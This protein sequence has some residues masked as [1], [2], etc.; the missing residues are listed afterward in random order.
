MVMGMASDTTKTKEFS[1]LNVYGQD[2]E[3]METGNDAFYQDLNLL[4]VIDK[5]TALW[6]KSVRKLFFFLPKSAPETSYRRDVYAD[7]KNEKVYRALLALTEKLAHVREM[8]NEKERTSHRLQR[9][10]WKLREA[11][12]YC[13]AYEELAGALSEAQLSSDGMREF[14]AHLTEILTDGGFL[15]MRRETQRLLSEIQG[16]RFI[17]TYERDRISV[18]PVEGGAPQGASAAAGQRYEEWLARFDGGEGAGMPNPFVTEPTLSE[19]EKACL[20]ML[21]S[22]KPEFFTALETA[23]EQETEYERSLLSR[24][25]REIPFYLAFRGFQLEMEREG[26]VFATPTAAENAPMEAKGLYD[27]ALALASFPEGRPVI[28][29]DCYYGE[30][31]RFFV[32]TGPNQGGKTTFARSLGQLVFFSAMGLDVPAKSANV[33]FFAGLQTHFS[34]EES[35]ETGRGKLMEELVRLAP[36]MEEWK[37]GSFVVINELFTTAANYDAQIMGKRVLG[38][39][40]SLGC[41]GIYVT[42]LAELAEETEGI[43]SLRAMLD[44]HGVQTFEIRRGSAG[45]TACAANQVNKYRLTYEQLKERL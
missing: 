31:E 38:H 34:V 42:H 36:M 23:A 32:L 16:I 7:V 40:L 21:K 22:K 27:V 35:M 41:M 37:Q 30:G 18:E 5:M 17:V 10:V 24:F 2:Y 8:R 15:Q 3:A 4:P 19:L 20:E 29:N 9:A 1:I 6:G 25:E 45:D 13:S 28:S 43:V 11:G 44:E 12:A 14:L 33:P 39:F 26:F